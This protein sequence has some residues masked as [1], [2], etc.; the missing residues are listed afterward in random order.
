MANCFEIFNDSLLRVNSPFV[1]SFE[2]TYLFKKHETTA[3]VG[4]PLNEVTP[5]PV[6]IDTVANALENSLILSTTKRPTVVYD[7][8]TSEYRIF[9]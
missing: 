7:T 5:V 9:D 8:A 2:E 3:L 6:P 4:T 1:V